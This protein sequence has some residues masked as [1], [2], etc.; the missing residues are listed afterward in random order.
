[1]KLRYSHKIKEVQR[2]GKNIIFVIAISLLF[3]ASLTNADV[4]GST[5]RIE[6]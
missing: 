6:M 5:S 4:L 2:E 1:M 3:V